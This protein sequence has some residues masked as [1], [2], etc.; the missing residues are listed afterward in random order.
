MGPLLH[1]Q[2][3]KRFWGSSKKSPNCCII[4]APLV[5]VDEASAQGCGPARPSPLTP[6]S[7]VFPTLPFPPDRFGDSR[8]SMDFSST[9]KHQKKNWK[10]QHLFYSRI[11]LASLELFGLIQIL[12]NRG[13][14]HRESPTLMGGKASA[15]VKTIKQKKIGVPDSD[16]FSQL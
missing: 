6:P 2:C 11:S 10:M 12:L 7:P 13:L 5:L 3:R 16:L 8:K 4:C 14:R 9:Q 15:N 1:N